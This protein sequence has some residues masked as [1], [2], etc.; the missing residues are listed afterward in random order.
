MSNSIHEKKR[1]V[2][3]ALIKLVRELHN[4]TKS[5]AD[6]F[7]SNIPVLYRILQWADPDTFIYEEYI[8]LSTYIN[9]D[10]DIFIRA[11]NLMEYQDIVVWHEKFK[12]CSP[13]DICIKYVYTVDSAKVRIS[14]DKLMSVVSSLPLVFLQTAFTFIGK[15]QK[16]YDIQLHPLLDNLTSRY[17]K[18]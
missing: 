7:A 18:V 3:K 5:P 13:V 8:E 14:D 4:Y 15:Y 12:T 6:E 17:D 10:V 2:A 9:N 1:I 16:V 11:I